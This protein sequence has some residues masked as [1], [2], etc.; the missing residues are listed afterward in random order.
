MRWYILR[1]LWL[2]EVHRHLANRGSLMLIGVLLVAG[3]LLSLFRSNPA[4]GLSLGGEAK[5][6]YIDYSEDGP[7]IAYLREHL[8]EEWRKNDVVAFRL[9]AEAPTNSEGKIDYDKNIGAIQV[10][11]NQTLV[12]DLPVPIRAPAGEPHYLVMFWHPGDEIG[13]LAP[14]EAWF[15]KETQHYMQDRMTAAVERISPGA[16][17][18][19]RVLDIEETQKGL[20]GT[21]DPRTAVATALVIFALFFFC[22]YLM[23]TMTCEERERGV[24][25]AQALSPASPREILVAKLLFYPILGMGLAGLLAGIYRPVVLR[26]PF[27]WLVLLVTAVGFQGIGLTIASLARTQRAASLGVMCYLALIAL[28]LIIFDVTGTRGLPNLFLEFHVPRMLHAIMINAVRRSEQ[29]SLAISAG[30][31][32]GWTIAAIHLFRKQGWQ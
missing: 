17:S 2:K 24:L 16:G 25:L 15:W 9:L 21:L 13:A 12:N 31:A 22:V 19:L 11:M 4:A 23:P 1:T 30:L 14:F 6:C 28:F 18:A 26:Q 32:F 3:L 27:F 5:K 8:P 7:W 29:I 10:R 20:S